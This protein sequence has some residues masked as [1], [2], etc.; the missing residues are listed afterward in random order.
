MVSID[1]E[2]MLAAAA[3]HYNKNRPFFP[4]YLHLI[5]SALF[6]IYTGAYASLSRPSSAAKPIKSKKQA[7]DD[8]DEEEETAQKME[9]LSPSDAIIFPI[10]AGCVLASLYWLIKTYGAGVINTVLGVYFS[11]IGTFS[12]G[13]L[14]NDV[15]TTLS[16]F[17]TPSYYWSEHKIWKVVDGERK[18]VALGQENANTSPRHSPLPGSMG[19][20]PLPQV[21][22]DLA[23]RLRALTKQKFTVKGYAKDIIE[24]SVAVTRH[25]VISGF[26]GVGAVAYSLL[27][28][29]PWFLTNLQGFAVCYG[30]LQ[31]MSPTTF[32][33]G[34]LILSGLFFYD[35]W[36]VF[37]TPLMVTVATNLD[38]PIKLVFPRPSEEGE[39]PAFSMLGLGDIVLPGI[40]IALALRFDL[41]VFYLR[42]Q[43]KTSKASD[44]SENDKTVEVIEKAPYVP[45]SGNWAERLF[46][47]GHNAEGLPASLAATFPKPYFTASLVGYVIGMIA[48]LVFMS[49]FQHAQP[50]LLYLVPG[51]LISLW[52]TGLVRG[53]LSEMWEYTEAITGES[54]DSEEGNEKEAAKEASSGDESILTWAWNCVFGKS[55]Q[56][57]NLK[58]STDAEKTKKA[59]TKKSPK[60][61]AS[62]KEKDARPDATATKKTT[63]D[64]PFLSFT[65]SHHSPAVSSTTSDAAASESKSPSSEVESDDAVLVSRSDADAPKRT[66]STRSRRLRSEAG[67]DDA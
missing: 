58:K 48:T 33:T 56:N 3:Y 38:V 18:A 21:L 12:V 30:A 42:K 54:L 16:G 14:I 28:G 51:V 59:D 15:W 61:S 47:A 60:S 63:A 50:A 19:G 11:V 32:A 55:G 35:I 27:V 46:T 1:Y 43:K 29:K 5:T 8:E 24:F 40:M 64:E 66:R 2:G 49:I 39:K 4:M 52:G 65:I 67:S 17:V 10:T 23:W 13:K 36:A 7:N 57:A 34:T 45:V 26:L 53:E 41:Y 9:G 37:F 44:A 62:S 22:L 6:P 31:L 20:L 25:N